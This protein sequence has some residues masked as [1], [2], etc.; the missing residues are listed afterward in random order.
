MEFYLGL[1]FFALGSVFLIIEVRDEINKP[2]KEHRS[3]GANRYL[4]ITNEIKHKTGIALL[5]V[6]GLCLILFA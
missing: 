3:R 1:V 6:S 2:N 5:I 4:D